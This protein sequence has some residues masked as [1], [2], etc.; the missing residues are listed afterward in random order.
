LL[1]TLHALMM[2]SPLPERWASEDQPT[3]AVL[4]LIESTENGSASELALLVPDV[5]T[6]LVNGGHVR[7]ISTQGRPGPV[8]AI[9]GPDISVADASDVLAWGDQID[10]QYIVLADTCALEPPEPSADYILL[11]QVLHTDTGA[12]VYENGATVPARES[13]P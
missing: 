13:P 10:A 9:H 12:V 3:V 6:V 7:V 8:H 1:T 2:A 11:L 5:E 4:A